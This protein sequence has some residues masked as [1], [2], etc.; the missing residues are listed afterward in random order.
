MNYQKQ[1]AR[2]FITIN[3]LINGLRNN[4]LLNDATHI[5]VYF[6]GFI[7]VN[8]FYNKRI[9]NIHVLAVKTMNNNKIIKDIDIDDLFDIAGGTNIWLNVSTQLNDVDFPLIRQL[10]EINIDVNPTSF[11]TEKGD[12]IFHKVNYVKT[13]NTI[14][15]KKLMSKL[16]N[17]LNK[18]YTARFNKL[19]S[20]FSRDDSEFFDE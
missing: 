9:R 14:D 5:K 8:N 1:P 4:D 12:G 19:V 3:K 7:S 18:K 11:K 17:E 6:D 16:N 10:N 15:N 13:K 2:T 20:S